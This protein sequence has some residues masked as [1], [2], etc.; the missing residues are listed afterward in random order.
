MDAFLVIA[1]IVLIVVFC[2]GGVLAY[3]NRDNR[4][5]LI[6][7]FAAMGGALIALVGVIIALGR[8]RQATVIEVEPHKRTVAPS[9]ADKA[10][11]DDK[12]KRVEDASA[13]LKA[14]G[15][16]LDRESNDLD[17]KLKS[18]RD[19]SDETDK[20]L[21]TRVDRDLDADADV[22]DADIASRLRR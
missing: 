16:K 15:E 17:A 18:A 20:A 12:A 9:E 2:V 10:L 11:L 5:R 4:N 21:D 6:K 22:P 8:K 1:A 3:K 13:T 19:A 7:I 14:D